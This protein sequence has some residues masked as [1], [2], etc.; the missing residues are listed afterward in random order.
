MCAPDVQWWPRHGQLTRR[1]KPEILWNWRS[2][3]GLGLDSL[4]TKKRKPVGWR[5]RIIWKPWRASSPSGDRH[6]A[7][8]SPAAGAPFSRPSADAIEPK[9]SHGGTREGDAA[10]PLARSAVVAPVVAGASGSTIAPL[11]S[12][13]RGTR[14]RAPI[15]PRMNFGVACLTDPE[16]MSWRFHGYDHRVVSVSRY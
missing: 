11:Q 6:R 15:A 2:G 9:R 12:R 10:M 14:D 7:N 3:I 13:H 4:T 16:R 8:P 5:W 1:G